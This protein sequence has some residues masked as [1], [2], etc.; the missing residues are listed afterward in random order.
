[1]KTRSELEKIARFKERT[2]SAQSISDNSPGR[3]NRPN[4]V[5]GTG[6]RSVV[7]EQD[8]HTK[9]LKVRAATAAYNTLRQLGVPVHNARSA[10]VRIA[11][12]DEIM[13]NVIVKR[14]ALDIKFDIPYSSPEGR[15]VR[16]A[17]I[18]VSYENGSLLV[19]KEMDYAGQQYPVTSASLNKIASLRDAPTTDANFTIVAILGDAG[20][21]IVGATET[22]PAVMA[23][24]KTAGFRVAFRNP[25]D[26]LGI[27]VVAPFYEVLAGSDHVA[28]KA[29]IAKWSKPVDVKK[30][31]K[32]IAQ[33]DP[34]EIP[35]S[36]TPKDSSDALEDFRKQVN[37]LEA[38]KAELDAA[39]KAY[40]DGLAK[41]E[42]FEGMG[43]LQQRLANLQQQVHIAAE[44]VA[45]PL[46]QLRDGN[47]LA[48]VSSVRINDPAWKTY[49]DTLA[50]RSKKLVSYLTRWVDLFRKVTVTHSWKEIA[51]EDIGKTFKSQTKQQEKL[52]DFQSTQKDLGGKAPAY[53]LNEGTGGI[54][55]RKS[56]LESSEYEDPESELILLQHAGQDIA[57]R[58]DVEG[59]LMA[60]LQ[61]QAEEQ[62]KVEDAEEAYPLPKPVA[63]SSRSIHP[64]MALSSGRPLTE[65]ERMAVQNF[66]FNSAG[67]G[68]SWGF[69]R[70]CSK[71]GDVKVS[72]LLARYAALGFSEQEAREEV[73][74]KAQASPSHYVEVVNVRSPEAKNYLEEADRQAAEQG[75]VVTDFDDFTA[76]P[77]GKATMQAA[78]VYFYTAGS[79]QSERMTVYTVGDRR[80][81]DYLENEEKMI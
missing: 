79:L 30:K 27:E 56:Q 32:R 53:M 64:L 1:M 24:L 31:A 20:H 47:L 15:G 18:P 29:I 63:A 23:A 70:A 49:L 51:P 28:A 36:T 58:A 67:S 75:F 43:D 54:S 61:K 65:A 37:K 10:E 39:V 40:A 2:A 35:A 81:I 68:R 3:Y 17:S 69:H 41:K 48:K 9:E 72:G 5:V 8:T 6:D 7:A 78:T 66:Q 16:T 60:Q 26:A 55:T 21:E 13:G 4:E 76:L 77:R 34:L 80:F 46:I 62:G 45:A 38:K 57:D 52:K 50:K 74:R 44:A 19:G 33:A 59:Q 25:Q 42:K 14:A 73:K 12:Q 71:N 11:E 22:A